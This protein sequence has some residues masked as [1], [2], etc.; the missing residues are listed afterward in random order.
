MKLLTPPPE[1]RPIRDRWTERPGDGEEARFG[2][3][4]RGAIRRHP[5]GTAELEAVRAQV[6]ATERRRPV[7]ARRWQLRG[8]TAGAPGGWCARRG[9]DAPRALASVNHEARRAHQMRPRPR[10]SA[11]RIPMQPPARHNPREPSRQ[12]RRRES[13]CSRRPRPRFGPRPERTPRSPRSNVGSRSRER[14]CQRCLRRRR[15]W[16]G[17]RPRSRLRG[18]RPPRRRSR[19]WGR[20]RGCSRSL[21]SGCAT[22]TTPGRRSLCSTSIGRAS[23]M[24]RSRSRRT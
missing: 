14:P 8:G 5:L 13:R 9:Q 15:S 10:G 2:A 16:C 11:T 19:L 20:N 17:R 24:A 1:R 12:C 21:C 3:L 4:L 7:Y 6:T 23:P 18:S 22:I